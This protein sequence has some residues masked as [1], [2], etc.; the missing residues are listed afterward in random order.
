[1]KKK[2]LEIQNLFESTF[3]GNKLVLKKG[4]KFDKDPNLSLLCQN[5]KEMYSDNKKVLK[6]KT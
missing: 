3:C 5:A 1:M 6:E 4:T 2:C